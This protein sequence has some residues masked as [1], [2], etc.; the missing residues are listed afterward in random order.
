MQRA[1]FARRRFAPSFRGRRDGFLFD[2]LAYW[3]F[4]AI[5][6]IL[7]LE[8]FFVTPYVAPLV[9]FFKEGISPMSWQSRLQK[10]PAV[11]KWA[12][13]LFGVAAIGLWSVTG[14]GCDRRPP[15]VDP[16]AID[17]GGAAAK[18]IQTY[19]KNGDGA[20]SGEELDAVPGIKS[21]LKLYDK[22][23]DGRVTADEIAAR[24][25]VWKGS[26][27]G[28]MSAACTVKIDGKPLEGAEVEFIPEEYLGT[29]IKTAR[30]TTG[31]GGMVALAIAKDDLPPQDKDLHGMHVGT[32]KIKVTHPTRQIP[33]KYNTA[34]TI[35]QE[36]AQDVEEMQQLTV[37][38]TSR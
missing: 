14:S 13:V 29:A 2:G 25:N 22:N 21:A 23:S 17:P 34:T 8:S 20:I 11:D 37:E 3:N 18:A 24:I 30:G 31:P 32:Y 10:F 28:I 35:G 38:I 15:R 26:Q 19:D 7:I 27:V 33:A 9:L 6:G 16:P 4:P 1:G 12:P 5:C 36:I